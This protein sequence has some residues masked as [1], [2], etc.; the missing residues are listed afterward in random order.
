MIWRLVTYLPSRPASGRRVD[1]EGHPQGRRV[2]VEPR[3]RPRIGGIG[4]RVA[5]RH[6]GQARDADDVARTG[7]RDVDAV[8]PVRGLEARHGPAERHR[9]ARLHGPGRVVGLLAHDRDA[10]ADPDTA[11]PDPPDRHPP[12]VVVGAQVRDQ[13]LERMVGRVG[14]RRGDLDQHVEQRPQVLA[15]LVERRRRRAGLGV[16]VDDREVDLV[17]VGA[18]VHEQL[19]DVVEDLGRTG[20]RAVDLV[21][22]DDHRQAPGHRLLEDVAGLRQR[23]LRR[24]H[25]EQHGIDH[26]QRALDL[27]AEVGVPGRVD[28]VEADVG[29]VDRGLLGEDRDAL[30][31]LEVARVHDPV[32]DGLVASGTRPVWRS[33]AS[34]S[35]VLPWSTW[36]TMATLRRS[37]RLAV[38]SEAAVAVRLSGTVG[39][40]SGRWWGRPIVP[41]NAC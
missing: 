12:D 19:V 20:V 30:L 25:E 23:A 41:R 32:H 4:Q 17:L 18:E 1:A 39:R 9:P 6:L 15:G 26:E 8:D 16:R 22:R 10:L 5:D 35:V 21:E 38:A 2:D 31:A 29:V 11:V 37:W 28:D 27:A 3:Q 7:L 34:T 33:I 24:V 40:D 14:R 13:Q 36:A